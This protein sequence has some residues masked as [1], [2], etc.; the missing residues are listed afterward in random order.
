MKRNR[1]IGAGILV[2]AVLILNAAV[3]FI[4]ASALQSG[5][6]V[7]LVV[8]LLQVL[9]FIVPC[10]IYLKLRRTADVREFRL[11]LPKARH[12]TFMLS[13]LISMISG[14]ALINYLMSSLVGNAY[15]ESS[16]SY[17]SAVFGGGVSGG[18]YAVV[19]FALLPAV[20]EELLFRGIVLRE[21]ECGGIG[22]AVL[23]STMLFAMSH[24]SFV[25]APVYLFSGLAL[26]FALY[27]TES[28]IASAA[29]HA[30]YNASVLFLEEFV[31]K[32]VNRQGIVIFLF[33]LGA[34]L[35][36]SL[37]FAFGEAEKIYSYY[38][39]M[40]MRSPQIPKKKERLSVIDALLSP[41]FIAICA[42][43][44]VMTVLS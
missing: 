18:I 40:N 3:R 17:T 21:Y 13:V 41:T 22:C 5:G 27:V 33:V 9:I 43:Y 20:C 42:F 16:I 19:A 35:L 26:A 24:F 29:L 30:A 25:R 6:E 39:V 31:Y 11:R 10:V 8:A 36:V 32:V 2:L 12:V 7:Y 14:S 28:V 4:P 15:H 23:F 37:V 44:I 38:G 34:V 1:T